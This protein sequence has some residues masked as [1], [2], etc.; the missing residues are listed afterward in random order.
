MLPRYYS[1]SQFENYFQKL[2]NALDGSR[3]KDLDIGKSVLK[4]SIY[5]LKIGSGKVKVLVWSQMHG[6]ESSTTR[7]ICELLKRSDLD[8]ILENIEL[9]IIPILNPDGAEKWTRVNANNVDLNRDAVLLSQ[10]ES[11][12][13]RKVFDQFQPHYCFNLH[14]QRSI[15]GSKNGSIPAQ[16]SFLAPAGD[17][18]KTLSVARIKAMHVINSIN[19]DL[20]HHVNGIIGR[21]NDDFNINCV[22]DF[23]MSSSVPT[24][25]FEA[26]HSGDD[27][28]RDEVSMLVYKALQIALK[29]VFTSHLLDVAVVNAYKSIPEMS[30]AYVDIWIKNYKS[31]TGLQH[32]S[33]Q[34]HEQIKDGELYF[35]PIL[36]G[37]NREDVLNG[38]R[39]I[40][41]SDDHSFKNDLIVEG[42]FEIHSESLNIKIFTN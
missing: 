34:Y 39:V 1:Y 2:L 8:R 25:L 18:N 29:S 6:N 16:L 42:N 40:D 31:S 12:L 3:L 38:H 28:S 35:I 24:V 33:I 22:G 10:P 30:K 19:T 4:R 26:G 7:A 37:V 21:Y 15:Y 17:E 9:Y 14:G 23:M 41:M 11:I 20:N 32:L 27:Y 36:I 5:G 13:L